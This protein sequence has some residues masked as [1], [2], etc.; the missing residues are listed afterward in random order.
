MS[1]IDIDTAEYNVQNECLQH[2]TCASGDG[3]EACGELLRQKELFARRR[4]RRAV[5]TREAFRVPRVQ[6]VDRNVDTE[7]EALQRHER[8]L[9]PLLESPPRPFGVKLQEK[10]TEI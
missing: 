1:S 5:Q 6:L 10:N 7:L 8:Q 9:I 4:E 2:G 3:V